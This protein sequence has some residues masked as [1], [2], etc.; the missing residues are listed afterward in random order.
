MC[1]QKDTWEVTDDE[2]LSFLAGDRQRDR[3]LC[4]EFSN[5][6]EIQGAQEVRSHKL[7]CKA[8]PYDAP[9]L[10]SWFVEPAELP[11]HELSD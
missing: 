7:Y 11:H 9:N 3:L 6:R 8:N 1:K 10:Y 4:G 2:M 5:G